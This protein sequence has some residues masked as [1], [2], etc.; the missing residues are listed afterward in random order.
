MKKIV[1]AVALFAATLAHAQSGIPTF[2]YVSSAPTGTCAGTQPIQIVFST[3]NYY[4]CVGTTWTQTNT[5]G[6]GGGFPITLGS[7]PISASATVTSIAGLTL[8]GAT[9]TGATLTTAT[10]TG[11]TVNGVTP[12]TAGSSTAFLNGAG[13]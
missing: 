10:I 9:L 4:S 8:T 13:S 11:A 2:Q 12:T 7:T 3:G 1:F 6:G 5:G